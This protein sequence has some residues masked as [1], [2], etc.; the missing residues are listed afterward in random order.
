MMQM[1]TAI[2]RYF[3]DHAPVWDARMPAHY[4]EML[5]DFAR[6]FTDEF[7]AAAAIAEI[8]TGTGALI[9]VLKTLAPD[10]HLI[11]ADFA[12]G[13]VSQARKRVPD[14]CLFQA[15]V[16]DLPLVS[17]WVDLV[18]CHNSFPHF[19]DK[20]RAL[21]EIRRVLRPAGK[22]MILH[23]NPREVVN[24]IHQRAGAPIG[25]DLLP[26]GDAMHALLTDSG[27]SAVQVEDSSIRYVARGTRG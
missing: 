19:V 10:S 16:H 11:S 20:P 22:L 24:A 5:F 25:G 9:P 21:R 13:M 26:Q 1:N 23:N 3:E 18:I 8:G 17:K 15:D 14:T 4:D 2:R 12:Y 7:R 6:S 27:F